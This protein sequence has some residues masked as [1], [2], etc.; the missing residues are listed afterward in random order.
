MLSGGSGWLIRSRYGANEFEIVCPNLETSPPPDYKIRLFPRGYQR[1]V[2][3][4]N[5][6]VRALY[7]LKWLLNGGYGEIKRAYLGLDTFTIIFEME[8]GNKDLGKALSKMED[9]RWGTY[10]ESRMII[11]GRQSRELR[12][13]H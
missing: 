10:G 11:M 3:S 8:S 2:Q 1:Y 4:L 13:E 6:R 7:P 5:I 9:E 12:S